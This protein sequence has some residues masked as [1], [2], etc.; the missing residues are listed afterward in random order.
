MDRSDL[1]LILAC[2][3]LGSVLGGPSASADPQPSAPPPLPIL[4][5]GTGVASRVFGTGGDVAADRLKRDGH[6]PAMMTEF[7]LTADE[8]DHHIE[9]IEAQTNHYRGESWFETFVAFHNKQEL[10]CDANPGSVLD[11]LCDR[12][13]YFGFSYRVGLYEPPLTWARNN[14]TQYKETFLG[15]VS[16]EG[17]CTKPMTA[18]P[19]GFHFV[20]SG[21]RVNYHNENKF[22]RRVSILPYSSPGQATVRFKDNGNP[23]FEANFNGLFLPDSLFSDFKK[24]IT[25]EYTPGEP[26]PKVRID[27]AFALIGFDFEF[28]NGD[29]K[30]STIGFK[31]ERPYLKPKFADKNS[32]DPWR[33]KIQYALLK[34]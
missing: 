14:T 12:T 8:G 25:L 32:D 28:L 29:H 10:E 5:R 15:D 17:S 18:P 21:F 31:Y 9:K 7:L 1:R 2:V 20:L 16:C 23:K 19:S 6:K 26:A 11:Q 33:V 27:G 24:E 22:V 3:L 13:Y 30:L 4:Q 34:L